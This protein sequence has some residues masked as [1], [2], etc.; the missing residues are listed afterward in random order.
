MK[1]RFRQPLD[2]GPLVTL[3]HKDYVLTLMR[4]PQLAIL[5]EVLDRTARAVEMVLAKGAGPAMNEFNRRETGDDQE[6]IGE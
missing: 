2:T 1:H 4:K 6:R 5:D 3:K